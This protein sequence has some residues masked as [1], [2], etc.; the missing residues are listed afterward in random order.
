MTKK[1]LLKWLEQQKNKALDIVNRQEAAAK[2][3]LNEKKYRDTGLEALVAEISPKLNEVYDR[4]M[5]WHGQYEEILGPNRATYNSV[6]TRL[7]PLTGTSES[8]LTLMKEQEFARTVA[9]ADLKSRFS[10]LRN[11][12]MR[13]YGN[14]MKNVENLANAKLGMDYLRELG[15]D[16]T[17]LLALEEKPVETAL[18]VPINTQF[19]LLR[20]EADNGSADL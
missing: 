3:E 15:F 14:V 16:L 20:K 2:A 13:T 8:L 6:G 5:A 9:D 11:E 1:L 4:V 19:L 17:S 10:D 18:A 7:Y 12:V